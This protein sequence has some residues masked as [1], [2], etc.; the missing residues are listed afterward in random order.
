MKRA[1]AALRRSGIL[2]WT[3][4]LLLLLGFVL[5]EMYKRG[6]AA[7]TSIDIFWFIKLALFQSALY[8]IAAWAITRARRTSYS[9]LILVIV[10]AAFFRLSILYAPPY[11]S[12]DI[13]RYIWD[14]RVQAA[15]INPYKYVPADEQLSGLRDDVIYKE[16]NRKDFARTIY[17][18][19]AQSVFYGTT[20]V[21]ETVTWMKATMVVFEALTVLA[22]M[23]LLASFNL[24]LQ[25]VLI[26]AWHPLVVW[27]FA[28]SGHVDAVAVAFVFIAL[29]ARRRNSET[30]TGIALGCAVLVK[31]FPLVLFPALYKRWG[32]RMP[33]AFV[34]TIIVSYLPY[35][36]IGF[37]N[38][39]GYLPGYA[40]EEGISG[41]SR[42]FFLS[43]ARR[44]FGEANVPTLSFIIIAGLILA[45][46]GLWALFKPEASP[47][48]FLK[49]AFVLAAAFILLLSPRYEWYFALLVPF[50]SFVPFVP[51]FALTASGFM[52]YL[53]WF[54]EK[55]N[56]TIIIHAYLYALFAFLCLPWLWRTL[57]RRWMDAG[58]HRSGLHPS[59]EESI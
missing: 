10:F 5:Q 24:P 35:V 58:S 44:L 46:L 12:D 23:G 13:Y 33:V 39:L 20:R 16:I 55:P 36:S 21:S 31:L 37:R 22:L 54:E 42:F 45:A 56:Q 6:L 19:L 49:R 9:T 18:P 26:Y 34:L 47:A 29:L 40:E 43:L 27:E 8:L 7:K 17:P 15:G 38:A 30:A 41:G 4:L 53:L 59:G 2:G 50:L 3:N 32:W 14:G 28:G 57:R 25:R 11:L 48:S 51:M 52:L 1:W